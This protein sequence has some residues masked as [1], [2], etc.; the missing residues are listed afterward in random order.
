MNLVNH[1]MRTK[2]L[3][4]SLV[5]ILGVFVIG[6]ASISGLNNGNTALKGINRSITDIMKLAEMKDRLLTARLDI[7]YMMSLD[8]ESKLADKQNDMNGQINAIRNLIKNFESASLAKEESELLGI[9]KA[10]NE[11]YAEKGGRLAEMLMSA[12]RSKDNAALKEAITYGVE[13]VAPLYKKPSEAIS[14][15]EKYNVQESESAFEAATAAA[16]R[17]VYINIAIIVAVIVMSV[18]ICLFITRSI[19]RSLA[20]VFETMAAVAGGDLTARSSITST[21]EMGLLGREMNIMAEKLSEIIR[22]LS[23]NSNSVSSAAMQMHNTSEQMSTSTEQLAAQA[24]TIATACEEMSATSSE[25][26][27]N[28]LSA[29][30][31]SAKA[32]ESAMD[33]SK[34]VEETVAIMGSIAAQVRTTAQTVQTLGS[35]SDQIGEIIGTIEDIADQTNLLALNAAIEAARASASPRCSAS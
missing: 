30:N 31:E 16:K 29:A 35:K 25:I 20:N 1:K 11:E 13:K 10:G 24:S 4:L 18:G 22:R 27:R 26:A 12:H 32:S 5:G 14:S 17:Q 3:I 7:V 33:G 8:D 21:D 9:F 6:G 2:L 15:L 28:C 19:T 23:D 34:V